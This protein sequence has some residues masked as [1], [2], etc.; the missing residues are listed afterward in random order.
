MLVD[1]E[2][3]KLILS[4]DKLN[5]DIALR[6]RDILVARGASVVLSRETNDA[7]T[8]PWPPDTN[9]DGIEGGN[10]DD[11]QHRIDIL[12]DFG[13]E[14]F[15][16]IHSN[17]AGNP[18]KRQ[19]IQ[20][21]YCATEDC[22]FPDKNKHLGTLTLDHLEA[23]LAM[24]GYPI[25][26]R[27]LRNDIVPEYPGAPETHYFLLGPAVPPSHPRATQMPGII[28]EALY[29][30]SPIEASQLNRDDVRQA[31]AVA[32]ADALEE[33]LTGSD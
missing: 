19:G 10:A 8:V 29:V 28:I 11:L 9:G 27:E 20:A 23:Q 5:L 17:S 12:N 15:L 33:Y 14:V 31:S 13:A 3:N 6:C 21:L 25:E 32:Y 4:E 7:F 22:A 24:T 18:A 16:S 2:T 30:T 1:P 26:R